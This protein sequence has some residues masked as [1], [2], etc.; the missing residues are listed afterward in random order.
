MD[1][2]IL[3]HYTTPTLS[4]LLHYRVRAWMM[5]N[6]MMMCC[7]LTHNDCP[8]DQ[9]GQYTSAGAVYWRR[10]MLVANNDCL[11]QSQLLG[12]AV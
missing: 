2:M 5:M 9:T 12:K 1:M 4:P 8:Y 10:E 7:Q 6:I 3:A 11:Y